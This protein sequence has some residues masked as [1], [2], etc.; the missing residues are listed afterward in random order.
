M[1]KYGVDESKDNSKLEKMA[2]EGCPSCGA[3]LKRHGQILL[4][5]NCGSQP[6]EEKE[7]K[8]E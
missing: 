5:P 3:A 2:G 1:E 6:F 8:E 4:C 7:I